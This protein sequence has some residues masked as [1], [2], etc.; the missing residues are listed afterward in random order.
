MEVGVEGPLLVGEAR[1]E[2]RRRTGTGTG[3]IAIAIGIATE[4]GSERGTE[5]DEERKI[6]PMRIR[7]GREVYTGTI[8]GVVVV[9]KY[10]A[11][12]SMDVRLT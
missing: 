4:T 1:R 2:K 7:T 9:G 5:T 12:E 10:P 11:S 8:R 6:G 3:E